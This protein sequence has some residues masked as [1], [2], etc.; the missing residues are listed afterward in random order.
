MPSLFRKKTSANPFDS[1]VDIEPAPGNDSQVGAH[2]SSD[3]IRNVEV[4]E[5]PSA[6]NAVD[7]FAD[8]WVSAL[9]QTLGLTS[10]TLPTFRDSRISTLLAHLDS[11]KNTKVLELGPLEA[12]HTY[13]LHE[14]GAKVTAIESNTHSY[15][16]CLVVKEILSLNRAHFFLGDFNPYIETTHE[17][18]DL[19]LASGVLYHQRDPIH[20]LENL[21]RITDRIALWTHYWDERAVHANAELSAALEDAPTTAHWRGRSVRT[22]PVVCEPGSDAPMSACWMERE[23]LLTVLAGLGYTDVTVLDDDEHHANGPAILLV[24]QR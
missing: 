13:M 11:I 16:K 23:G 1:V 4:H 10:G 21:S 20:L 6:Q 9:P 3:S 24:A 8:H 22:H 12:G 5:S 15:L 18:F 7:L 2:S 17:R 14:A 19:V